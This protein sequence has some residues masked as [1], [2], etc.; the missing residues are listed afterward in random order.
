MSK[1]EIKNCTKKYIKDGK[2]IKVLNN[3]SY[4]FS[5]NNLYAIMGDS[6]SGKTTLINVLSG[7]ITPD[8]GYIY[9][10][11]N[12]ILNKKEFTNNRNKNIGLV[13]QSFLLN[14]NL[15]ALENVLLPTFIN[16]DLGKKQA[17]E[18]AKKILDDL[19]LN[20]RI[21]HY[22]RELSGGEQQR[23]AFA[24]ALINNPS[25]ILADEPTGNLDVRNEKYI[26]ELLKKL[27]N[28]EGKC[29]IV[30][31]HNQKIKKYA[32]IVLSMNKGELNE[33]K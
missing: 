3:I 15:T 16:K 22:P 11:N 12:P 29:V 17:I 32:N 19:G 7:I 27:S 33:I 8:E 4:K 10:D 24:R 2:N 21:N 9:I 30:V 28:E 26:F 5:E 20:E 23:V 14:D 6:G 18:R 25:V 13:Y 1:I 31:S